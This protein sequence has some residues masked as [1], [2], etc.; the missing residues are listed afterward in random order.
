[1]AE[2]ARIS[3]KTLGELAMPDF[4]PRCFWIKQRAKNLPYRIFPG[5]FSSI[6]SYGK[7]IVQ[8]WFDRHG[9]PPAWLA[10]L[11]DIRGYVPPPH[12][13]KFQ[14]RDAETG[15]LLTGT[16]D[17]ILVLADESRIIVDYKTAKFTEFQDELFPMYEAQLNA[18]AHI[19]ER[20][21]TQPVA[22]LALVYTEPVTD[23]ATANDDSNMADGGFQMPFSARILRVE[24][25]PELVPELLR[26][27]RAILDLTGP[28]SGRTGCEDCQ[29]LDHLISTA[30]G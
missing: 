7:K 29:N 2:P 15:I 25:K 27:A 1:M 28:P 14:T 19:G 12:H 24:R 18:Y 22:A 16:P 6:D 4:C 5:I 11:G 10:G 20:T 8:G 30:R 23:D 26:R 17:G 13:S 9:A 21:W 3:A